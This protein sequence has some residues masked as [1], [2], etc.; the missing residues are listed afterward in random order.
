MYMSKTNKL[1]KNVALRCLS[2][3]VHKRKQI[4]LLT[5][6]KTVHPATTG[7]DEALYDPDRPLQKRE[8]I[9][10]NNIYR[11]RPSKVTLLK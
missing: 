1:F 11:I 3:P 10:F 6:L 7:N 9:S 2:Q 4:G 5:S 8:W